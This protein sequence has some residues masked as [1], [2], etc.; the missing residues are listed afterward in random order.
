M[1]PV[2]LTPPSWPPRNL[3]YQE[4][5]GRRARMGAAMMAPDYTWWHG[6]YELKKRFCA[7]MEEA[8][9]MIKNNRNA[10]QCTNFPGAGGST[11]PPWEPPGQPPEQKK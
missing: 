3:L 9:D 11:Q 7:I 2:T 8:Q 1:L 4:G 10:T 5:P 6:F